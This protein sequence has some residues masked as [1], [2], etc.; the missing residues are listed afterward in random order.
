[1]RNIFPSLKFGFWFQLQLR[2]QTWRK[3]A[4]GGFMNYVPGSMI[5]WVFRFAN[6]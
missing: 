5:F 1:M 4:A 3:L 2:A 6:F